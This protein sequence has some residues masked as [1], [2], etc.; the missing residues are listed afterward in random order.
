MTNK[1]IT[2]GL[3][4]IAFLACISFFSSCTYDYFEDETNYVVYAPKADINKTSE[5]YKINDIRILIYNGDL[6]KDRYSCNPFD[7]NARAQ[8]GNFHFKLFPGAHSVYCLTH[9]SGVNLS[10]ID[11]HNTARLDLKQHTNGLEDNNIAYYQE[12]SPILLEYHTP[13]IRFPGP[14]VTDTAWFETRYVGQIC[15]AFK[16]LTKVSPALTFSN[17][18]RVEIIASGVGV[19]QNLSLVTDSINTRSSRISVD[20]KMLLSSTLYEDPYKDFEFGFHNYYFP[21][22]EAF[23]E[24]NSVERISLDINFIDKDGK[25]IFNLPIYIAERNT[26]KPIILHMNQVLVV[27]VDGN[28]IQ[29]LTL[30]KPEDWNPNIQEGGDTT[31]GGGGI[32]M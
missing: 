26:R 25:S 9:I 27:T 2:G 22:P 14:L 13:I 29:V 15:V 8:V 17:I 4:F 16:N 20:D 18:K 7:E 30:N 31:P 32:E 21:S 1:K 19:Q 11:T 5:T 28:D 6:S 3:C 12:P 24:D 10:N 23:G